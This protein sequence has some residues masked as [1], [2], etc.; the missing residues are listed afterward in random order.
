MKS[1]DNFTA[2]LSALI[3]LKSKVHKWKNIALLLG[4]FSF[5]LALRFIFGGS[6]SDGSLAEG[7]SYIA[8]IKVEG[9][10]FEDD[11][12]S[13]TLNKIAEEKSVK[14]VIVNISSPGGGIVGSEILYNN[15]RAIAAVKPMV[16]IMGSVAASGGYM[17][18]IASDYIVAHNGT[19]TGSIGVLME[20]PNVTIL[21]NKV[22][23]KFHTYKSSPLKGSPAP[24]ENSNPMVDKVVQSSIND[25][26]KFFV[27]MVR[28]RRGKKINEKLSHIAFDGRVFTGRQAVE[29]GLIDKVGSKTDA[30]IYL[31]QNNINVDDLPLKDINIVK[32]EEKIFD[33]LLGM[34]PFFNHVKS[35]NQGNGIMAIM[36]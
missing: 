16:V 24:F 31:K 2:N 7:G 17:A 23:L 21:A 14:A 9:V 35:M 6:L 15:L 28:A 34:M 18:A 32:K 26:Y 25:S 33:K 12:R 36:K 22:G 29:V 3:Y 30:L 8:N 11:F 5:L 4:V 20:A 19:L 10:I 13:K 27:E 1:S